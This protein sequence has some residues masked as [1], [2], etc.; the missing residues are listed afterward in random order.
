MSSYLLSRKA[1][2][3]TIVDW[4]VLYM[5]GKQTES[6]ERYITKKQALYM[7]EKLFENGIITEK[8]YKEIKEK[9]E[10]K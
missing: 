6:L 1:I 4:E 8:L 2:D 5:K 10:E 9:M 3:L 7:A